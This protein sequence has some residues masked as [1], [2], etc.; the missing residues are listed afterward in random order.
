MNSQFDELTKQMAQSVTRRAALTK[1]GVG[2]AGMALAY[3][4]M[5]NNARA[6][7]AKPCASDS[8]CG[9]GRV[10]C[11]GTCWDRPGWCDPTVS[12]CC[13][14][15]GSGKHRHGATALTPCDPSYNTCSQGCLSFGCPL[16]GP[17]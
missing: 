17:L 5:A 13:Y 8:D 16:V 4:G 7:K 1:F 15:A 12:C 11:Q 3:F 14:C 9:S 10:C 6:D 2:L